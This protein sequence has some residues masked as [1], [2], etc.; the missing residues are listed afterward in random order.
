MVYRSF[1]ASGGEGKVIVITSPVPGDGKTTCTWWLA[2]VL[3]ADG[4]RVLS[5]DADLRRPTAEP[6]SDDPHELGLRG[7][8]LGKCNWRDAAD[9]VSLGNHFAI[10]AG[11]IARPE[12]LSGERMTRFLKEARANFDFVLIDSPSFPYVSDALVIAANADAALSVVRLQ[13]SPRKQT[14]DHV[15]QLS[16][17]VP[18]YGVVVNDAGPSPRKRHAGPIRRDRNWNAADRLRRSDRPRRWWLAA[19]FG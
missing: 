7:V 18:A 13:H 12:T 1:S 11:G 15:R 10:A 4:K 9:Q 17:M 8:L 6:D 16:A 5:I 19:V 2:S 14:L 3:A